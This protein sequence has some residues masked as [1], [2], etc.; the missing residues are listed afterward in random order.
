M[1]SYYLVG[2]TRFREYFPPEITKDAKQI[3]R[4]GPKCQV[5]VMS[6]ARPAAP[7]VLYV[8]PT[9][10]WKEEKSPIINEMWN[11]IERKRIGGGLRVYL[12]R[13]WY[14]SGDGELLGI[15]LFKNPSQDIPDKF[16]PY[17]TQVGMDPIWE[18]SEPNT[19]LSEQDF[20]KYVQAEAELS[21]EEIG[22][23]KVRVVGY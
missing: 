2:T 15:V 9:F 13:P 1:V 19:A 11:A 23:E 10:G 14:S 8:L 18:S 16:K 22:P 20:I 4:E 17:V 12:E 3:T 21:L 6:S 7:K 5:P